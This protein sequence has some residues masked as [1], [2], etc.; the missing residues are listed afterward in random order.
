MCEIEIS[1][2]S[3]SD[4][5][6]T[7]VL[8]FNAYKICSNKVFISLTRLMIPFKNEI[9]LSTTG[10]SSREI[11]DYFDKNN[12]DK[13]RLFFNV[14]AMGHVSMIGMGIAMFSN[15]KIICIDGDGSIIM[16]MGNLSSVGTSNLKKSPFTLLL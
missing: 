2:L 6:L 5:F 15:K 8:P 3:F 14:G 16:H 13:S 11:L 7:K 12:L 9:I 10:K 1:K 4:N